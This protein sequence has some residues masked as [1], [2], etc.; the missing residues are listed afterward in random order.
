MS[1]RIVL[2]HI[3][4]LTTLFSFSVKAQEVDSVITSDNYIQNLSDFV[5]LKVSLNNDIE[6]FRL[7]PANGPKIDLRPNTN[8]SN[9]YN[10]SYKF[11]IF[12]F[13]VSPKFINQNADITE[14]GNTKIRL[15]STNIG[16]SPKLN[17]FLSHQKTTGYYLENT[18]ELIPSW[19][20]G[21]PYI[22]FPEL[23][24]LSWQG[25]TTYVANNNY[26]LFASNTS[27]IRQ[28][29]S[30]GS[31]LYGLS[32][33]YFKIDDR[34]R[35][36]GTNS[37]QKSNNLE[38]IFSP[39]YAFTYVFEN[40]FFFS[41]GLTPG[42]GIVRSKL[43][44]RLTSDIIETTDSSII[45]KLESMASIGYDNGRFFAGTLILGAWSE[46]LNTDNSSAIFD[47]RIIYEVYIG[48]RFN[49]PSF[50][51]KS[52]QFISDKLPVI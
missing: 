46:R 7:T 27:Y 18:S 28:I 29:R 35:L 30:A 44:T 14:R 48:Y 1:K 10:F 3:F 41:G 15:F 22:Q 43:F 16:I 20:N 52:V 2:S 45:Y 6:Y 8:L 13:S 38:L 42:I 19:Q 12:S 5:S 37:S 26:S 47:D 34:T 40:D 21:D 9:S 11:I 36:N 23:N 31:F 50:L 51:K 49:T 39:G 25:I 4:F 17:Q 32:Y 33:K 24:Y